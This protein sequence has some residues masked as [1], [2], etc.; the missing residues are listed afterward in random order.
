[1]SQELPSNKNNNEEVDLIV[2]FNL[3]GNAFNKAY[4]FITSIVKSIFTVLIHTLLWV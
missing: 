1:M 2:F 4:I 3:I